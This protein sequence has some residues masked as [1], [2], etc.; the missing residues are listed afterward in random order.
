MRA[1]HSWRPS[2]PRVCF[3]SVNWTVLLPSKQKVFPGTESNLPRHWK[4]V[5]PGMKLAI[6]ATCEYH[7][8]HQESAVAARKSLASPG[9]VVPFTTTSKPSCFFLTWQLVPYIRMT[10]LIRLLGRS[11]IPSL[12]VWYWHIAMYSWYM[13]YSTVDYPQLY[14]ALTMT[15]HWW[16]AILSIELTII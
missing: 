2:D 12:D 11:S 10:K 15:K 7:F 16:L 1:H 8:S 3:F 4:H 5:S 9:W 6:V 13:P 14:Q